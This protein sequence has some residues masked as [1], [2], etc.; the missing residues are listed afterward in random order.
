MYFV[1]ATGLFVVGVAFWLTG[2]GGD[3]RYL[4]LAAALEATALVMSRL[5]KRFRPTPAE[6]RQRREAALREAW[7]GANREAEAMRALG[8]PPAQAQI[9]RPDAVYDPDAGLPQS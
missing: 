8:G 3:N 2:H 1:T 6:A 7:V 5:R 9:T 4:A